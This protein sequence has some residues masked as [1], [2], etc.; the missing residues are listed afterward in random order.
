MVSTF[1]IVVTSFLSAFS[2]N[3]ALFVVCRFV[4]GFFRPGTILGAYVVAGELLGPKYR[5][6]AGTALWVLFSMSLLLTGVKAYFIREWKILV[7]A[8]SA[9]YLFVC[10]LVL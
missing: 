4:V 2:P 10:F 5:P 9:P 7:I 3:F 1:A 8:C 6:A